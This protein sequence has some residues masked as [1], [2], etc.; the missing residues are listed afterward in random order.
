M[1]T[2]MLLFRNNDVSRDDGARL[3]EAAAAAIT[4]ALSAAGARAVTLFRGLYICNSDYFE[5]GLT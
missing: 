1:T 3:A 5:I 4:A 2:T